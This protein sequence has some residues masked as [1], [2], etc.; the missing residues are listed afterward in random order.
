[1][2]ND[3]LQD[4]LE[5]TGMCIPLATRILRLLGESGASQMEITT[6]LN[7]VEHLRHHLK[8]SIVQAELAASWSDSSA[9]FDHEHDA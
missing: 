8:G 7:L 3:D 6:A 9:D 2:A 1:M 5:R 4:A